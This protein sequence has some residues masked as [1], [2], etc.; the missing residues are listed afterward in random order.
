MRSRGRESASAELAVRSPSARPHRAPL[1]VSQA[2]RVSTTHLLACGGAV[3]H[4]AALCAGLVGALGVAPSAAVEREGAL[5]L[6]L[7]LGLALVVAL[8]LRLRLAATLARL[9]IT[10]AAVGRVGSLED[11]RVVR[12]GSGGGEGSPSL[13]ALLRSAYLPESVESES[14]LRCPTHRRRFPLDFLRTFCGMANAA[15][16][17]CKNIP[18]IV[19]RDHRVGV[20]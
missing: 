5:A 12:G 2:Y 10:A 7:G 17:N 20:R 16:T 15:G 1:L 11:G 9:T 14:A 3:H 8:A 4:R 19:T 18:Y 6:A 13:A